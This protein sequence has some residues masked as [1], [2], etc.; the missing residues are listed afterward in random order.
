MPLVVFATLASPLAA[1]AQ[2][3]L[4][5]QGFWHLESVR[6]APRTAPA[7]RALHD[8]PLDADLT[9]DTVYR[10]RAP[11]APPFA[12]TGETWTVSTDGRVLVHERHAAQ[13]GIVVRVIQ[14]YRRAAQGRRPVCLAGNFPDTITGRGE[15]P[16]S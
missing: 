9:G 3:A 12:P 2:G 7:C 11:S 15:A 16:K 13:G 6:C 1:A 8:S 10:G 14:T 4:P 5:L